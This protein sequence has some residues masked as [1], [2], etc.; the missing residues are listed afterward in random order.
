MTRRIS[1]FDGFLDDFGKIQINTELIFLLSAL[2]W[3]PK[4]KRIHILMGLM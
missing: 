3:M 4:L 2:V 1:I